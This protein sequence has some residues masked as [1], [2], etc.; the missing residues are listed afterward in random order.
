MA[1]AGLLHI[2]QDP[3]QIERLRGGYR[4]GE[5]FISIS[6]IN[7]SDHA[8]PI[9]GLL[10]HTFNQICGGCFTVGAGDA[11]YRQSLRRI[12]K[13]AGGDIGKCLPGVGDPYV[14]GFAGN[15]F[16]REDRDSTSFNRFVNIIV[17]VSCMTG[18]GNKQP[19]PLDLL[20]TIVDRLN[21]RIHVFLYAFMVNG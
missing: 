20:G 7:R 4:V 19:A 6:I 17:P 3:L 9:S 16:L 15:F 2:G 21:F 13:K 18:D 5:Y 10:Q 12:V 1:D 11:D 8:N 14:N